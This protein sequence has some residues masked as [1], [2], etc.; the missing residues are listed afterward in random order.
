MIPTDI[1]DR[2]VASAKEKC[3]E[4]L[5]HYTSISVLKSI[6]ENSRNDLWLGNLKHMND[7]SEELHF[8]RGIEGA[9]RNKLSTQVERKELDRLISEI[10]NEYKVDNF[11]GI[12]F[13]RLNDDAAQWERYADDAKGICIGFKTAALAKAVIGDPATLATAYYDSN[14]ENHDH[15]R[16]LF[17]LVKGEIPN[18]FADRQSVIANMLATSI[19]HKHQGFQAEQEIR[20][21]YLFKPMDFDVCYEMSNGVIRDFLRFPLR[22]KGESAGIYF[23]DFFDSIMIG[24]K[25]KQDIH[26]LRN[27]LANKG[28]YDMAARVSES[29]CPLR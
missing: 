29:T 18:C 22:Q 13:S 2:E 26:C 7:F 8:I 12:S 25:S 5:Y 27:Y 11:Y 15:T 9:V 10:E 17:E 3:G 28:L 21:V 16:N 19:S 23:E 20:L 6:V 14:F 1:I 24:P 4:V